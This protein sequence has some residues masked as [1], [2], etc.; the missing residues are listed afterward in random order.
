M[1]LC[2]CAADIKCIKLHRFPESTAGHHLSNTARRYKTL[3]HSER[4]ALIAVNKPDVSSYAFKVAV[5]YA[6]SCLL[7]GFVLL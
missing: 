4:W 3:S 2:M 5:F 6:L 1:C 7:T